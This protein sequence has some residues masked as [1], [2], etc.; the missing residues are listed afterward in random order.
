MELMEIKGLLD[1]ITGCTF[2]SLDTLTIPAPGA[3]KE[4]TGTLVIL[5]TNKKTRSGYENMV[6]RR[7]AGLG[8]D[9][10]T[11]KVD[12]LPWGERVPDSP[13]IKRLDGKGHSIYYLQTVLLK[14]GTPKYFVGRTEIAKKDLWF[15]DEDRLN[16]KQGLE[17]SRQVIVNTYLLASI[18][19]IRLMGGEVVAAEKPHAF[20][21]GRS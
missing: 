21:G 2:A 1:L 6:R 3:R 16:A 15:K 10:S 19:A 13:I 11:F 4:T 20:L 18:S 17:S 5:F 7:L 8:L 12:D 14:S 9:P